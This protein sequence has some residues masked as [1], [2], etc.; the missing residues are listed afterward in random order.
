MITVNVLGV[1]QKFDF[2]T[3]EV[4]NHILLDFGGKV[5]RAEVP[6]IDEL[7]AVISEGIGNEAGSDLGEEYNEERARV[8][9]ETA[10]REVVAATAASVQPRPETLFVSEPPQEQPATKDPVI[11]WA[12]LPEEVLP[13]RFKQAFKTLNFPDK[14]LASKVDELARSIDSTFT[15]DDWA[16]VAASPSSLEVISAPVVPVE[17][18]TPAQPIP[19]AVREPQPVAA[20]PAP[21]EGLTWTD[22]QPILQQAGKAAKTV[23]KDD[24]GYPLV[25]NAG[26]DTPRVADSSEVVDE[27]G[28]GQF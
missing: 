28:V 23:Q 12:N 19:P 11:E 20:P 9:A 27:S 13:P 2:A 5:V 17:D 3:K 22:G 26:V 6:D 8:R 15:E 10:A 21:V 18:T 25:P 16:D 24:Y 14:A 7:A 1:E 4:K